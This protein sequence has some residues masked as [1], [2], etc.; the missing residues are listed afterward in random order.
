[1]ERRLSAAHLPA[2]VLLGLVLL[3]LGLIGLAAAVPGLREGSGARGEEASHRLM[4]ESLLAERD[5]IFD[6]RD[7]RRGTQAW[8]QGPEGLVLLSHDDGRSFRYARSP[9]YALAALPFR[10]LFGEAG[11]Y[12]LN[13]A[14]LGGAWWLARRE[15]GLEEGGRNLLLLGCCFASAACGFA[16]R[17]GPEALCFA[18][19]TGALL[20]GRRFLA[21]A[22][23]SSPVLAAL[24]GLLLG[25]AV[26]LEP[27]AAVASGVVAV[28]AL[29]SRRWRQLA[30][31]LL[32]GLL[33]WGAIAAL[34][35][36]LQG[37]LVP[38]SH[39]EARRFGGEVPIE[40]RESLWSDTVP[41]A[42]R[43]QLRFP[44]SAA[45]WVH[46]VGYLAGGR[47]GGLLPFYPFALLALGSSLGGSWERRR[48]LPALGLLVGLALV[49]RSPAGLAGGALLSGLGDP[50]LPSLVPLAMLLPARS[51][52]KGLLALAW[53]AAGL[54]TFP[55]LVASLG[56][57]RASAPGAL[58]LLPLELSRLGA[59]RPGAATLAGVPGYHAR[60]L[61]EAIWLLPRDRFFVEEGN[62]RGVWMKGASAAEVIVVAPRPLDRLELVAVALAEDN[63]LR[64]EAGAGAERIRFDTAGKRAGAPVSL[65]L[66][67]LAR[68]LGGFFPEEVYYR[69]RL[70]CSSGAV[71]ARQN[72]A[73]QDTRYL[74]V[75]LDFGFEGE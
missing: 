64:L 23:T 48:W 71:P 26:S 38:T 59:A 25:A 66:A 16:F 72:P 24:A 12:L 17:V 52:G 6:H 41:E 27:L 63:E 53:L 19:V 73:S 75:F 7:A 18:L 45:A 61:G 10:G 30:A 39:A 4:T 43:A 22:P 46:E 50:R 5:L 13:L 8:P 68:N 20:A 40:G 21:A 31:F 49:V 65:P 35:L 69:L 1:M 15:L 32:A 62:P 34:E 67:P 56:P 54:F 29:V 58:A 47:S 42:R 28:D 60:A 44:R 14:L 57:G 37:T 51:P 36:R 55:A 3:G 2:S 74:G 33:A 11:F 70:S 9:A